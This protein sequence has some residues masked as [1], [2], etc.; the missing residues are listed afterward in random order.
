MDE[1]I[2]LWIA[3][4]VFDHEEDAQLCFEEFVYRSKIIESSSVD[5][6]TG[7]LRYKL[8]HSSV[9]SNDY[10]FRSDD[11]DSYISINTLHASI[12]DSF[13]PSCLT[14]LYQA[15]NLRTLLILHDYKSRLDQLPRHLFLKLPLLMALELSHTNI[16]ELPSTI[17]YLKD[18]RYLN[19]SFTPIT[20]LPNSLCTLSNL[21]TLGLRGCS[22]L[23]CLP[24][25]VSQ[26]TKLRHLNVDVT[27]L[28]VAMPPGFGDLAEL[29]TLPAFI[30]GKENG[31]HIT[32]LNQMVNLRGTF[33]I[34]RLENVSSSKEA[35]QAAL[36]QKK[37]LN[38]LE[39]H[40]S[41]L[42]DGFELLENLRPCN[43]IQE[44]E[45][46]GYGG[47]NFPSWI[48]EPLF[49]KLTNITI[50]DCR[51]CKVLP[52]LGQLL[53]LESLC[54]S[55][56]HAIKVI[57]HH[58]CGRNIGMEN[59]VSNKL[60]VGN[61][62]E[63]MSTTSMFMALPAFPA[64]K[65]FTINGMPMLE[66][67]CGIE[68]GDFPHL[69][70]LNISNCSKLT[71]LPKLSH[72]ELLK[73]L[74]ISLGPSLQSFSKEG[75]PASL[76][77]LVI[78]DC[79]LLKEKCLNDEEEN[80][81]KLGDIPNIWIDY[82]QMTK[83][84]QAQDVEVA[85]GSHRSPAPVQAQEDIECQAGLLKQIM[86]K[87]YATGFPSTI[88]GATNMVLDSNLNSVPLRTSDTGAVGEQAP[89]LEEQVHVDDTGSQHLVEGDQRGAYFPTVTGRTSEDGYN[90][91]K[92]GQK[93]VK[94]SGY[95]RSYYKCIHQNCLVKKKIEHSHDGQNTGFIY[96]GVHNHPMPQP[97]RQLARGSTYVL[98]EMLETGEDAGSYVKVE[99]GSAWKSIPQ[100]SRDNKIT[101][102]CR[103]N[104]LESTSSASV[105]TDVSDSSST[106]RE[107]HLKVSIFS[108]AD[109]PELPSTHASHDEEIDRATQGSIFSGDDADDDESDSKRRRKDS[110]FIETNMASRAVR[111][112]RYVV[113]RDSEVDFWDDG[114]CW[115]KYGQRVIKGNSNP[116][117][118]SLPSV[119][120]PYLTIPPGLRPT[121]LLDSPVMLPSSQALKTLS[122]AEKQLRTSNDK[123]TWLTAALLQLAPDQQYL[124][125]STSTET[126]FNHS[127]LILRNSNG[128]DV[129]R[130]GTSEHAQASINNRRGDSTDD[131]KQHAGLSHKITDIIR[132]GGED[133]SG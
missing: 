10:Y 72:L 58:F 6:S 46:L 108:G 85:D 40:W 121:S 130:I 59:L 120:S 128:R 52:P 29:Q 19:L 13:D 107:K 32:E 54:I 2:H 106:V 81:Q 122:E 8:N 24:K 84:Y 9:V 22:K 38:K 3:Q 26:L 90:W 42:Q 105:V 12:K 87:D 117:P 78:I 47:A 112:P 1:L 11:T 94:G 45:V 96:K 18:L 31:C 133:I 44:L 61:T 79:P 57:N 68:E 74:E 7:R 5:T 48:G 86:T 73:K 37:Y 55:D 82:Q 35:K 101:S 30:V 64:L 132:A 77:Y 16:K 127:P 103:G 95:W 80:W 63:H 110:C 15:Q 67:W 125:P 70:N 131:E 65:N 89:K 51:N 25:N 75:L 17:R 34:L 41:K 50:H 124:L 88:E 118:L 113:T 104:G 14:D 114:Y 69:Q 102:D 100:G 71:A 92:Y 115:R 53:S 36:E 116:S 111:E 66:E 20:T 119:R 23:I 83:V 39:L 43:E 91:R 4:G 98:S 129:W 21:Q 60:E 99:G 126:S 62:S 28:L 76:Q 97:S 49:I 109:T 33:R 56:M 93:Q 27:C 123:L